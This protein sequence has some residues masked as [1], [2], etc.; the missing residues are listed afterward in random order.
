KKLRPGSLTHRVLEAANRFVI[1]N[2]DL[3]VP[4]DRFMESRLREPGRRPNAVAVLPPWP[5]EEADQPSMAH[6]ANPFRAAHG[7]G[8]KF[9]VMYSGNHTPANPLDTLL[10]AMLA[11]KDDD[12]IRFL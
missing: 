7:L 5:H 6:D 9:V 1:R 11:F 2:A 8:D 10:D 4:L 12:S 3:S